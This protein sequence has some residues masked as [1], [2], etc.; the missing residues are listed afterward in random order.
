MPSPH[1]PEHPRAPERA[2]LFEI[3]TPG[4]PPIE[5]IEASAY[6]VPTDAPEAD[7][8]IEWDH[9]TMVLVELD[10]GGERGIGFSYSTEA[11]AR[12]VR[13][14][15]AG[16]VE[17]RSSL[18]PTRLRMTLDRAVRNAGLQGIASH[19]I[20]AIDVA[21]WDLKAKLLGLPL[22]TLLGKVRDAV[23][24]YGSGG[25]TSYSR[26]QLED[27]LRGWASEGFHAVKMKIG[28]EPDAD[29]ARVRVARDAIGAD[30]DLFVDAN[31]AY[32][33]RE[34]IALARRF[35]DEGVSWFEEPV[36]SDDLDGMRFVRE[37][38]PDR[39]RLAAGEYAYRSY[40]LLAFARAGAVDVLQADA[41]RC[42]GITGFLEAAALCEAWHLPLSA[43]TAPSIHL[44][45][46]CAVTCALAPAEYF[47]DHARIERMFFEGAATAR[48]GCAWPDEG[49]P[50][51]GLEPKRR[52]M[53]RF[54]TT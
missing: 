13:E 5:R 20:S 18:E 44:H 37:R 45:P 39:M 53:E 26:E 16:I 43:H 25:F 7:G 47:H 15:L 6:R 27:Q 30:V 23:P 38:L 51:L 12:L 46:C 35:A 21:A 42:G 52:E 14:L 34:A 19:A 49:R 10:A 41:T 24:L 22:C 54:R 32:H 29:P 4:A 31:G 2:H 9:T 40:D 1:G 17:G 28:S 50:G 33:P 8:T 36:T 3:P 48:G 11:A